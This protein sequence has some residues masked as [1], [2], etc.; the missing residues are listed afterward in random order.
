MS[1]KVYCTKPLRGKSRT[2]LVPTIRN[3]VATPDDGPPTRLT[4][5]HV[6]LLRRTRRT[7]DAVGGGTIQPLF[8]TLP[9]WFWTALCRRSLQR[10]LCLRQNGACLWAW[11]CTILLACPCK[12]LALTRHG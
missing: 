3:A 1:Q 2:G 12:L 5:Q 10:R 4:S 8:S 9:N 11:P 6:R 7:G